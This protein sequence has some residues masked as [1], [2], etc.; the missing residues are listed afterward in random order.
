LHDCVVFLVLLLHLKGDQYAV[1]EFEVRVVVL[2]QYAV[3]EKWRL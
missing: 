1:R 2:N 3:L